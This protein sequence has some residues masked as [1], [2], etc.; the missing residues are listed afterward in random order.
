MRAEN[1]SG[2]ESNAL[3]HL[4]EALSA[5]KDHFCRPVHPRQIFLR[6]TLSDLVVGHSF[7]LAEVDF[8]EAILNIDI[9]QKLVRNDLRTLTRTPARTGIDCVNWDSLQPPSMLP[10]MFTANG[11]HTDLMFPVA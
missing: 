1:L 8:T 6:V 4:L 2:S 11:G 10:D 3:T 5:G 9:T 7:E